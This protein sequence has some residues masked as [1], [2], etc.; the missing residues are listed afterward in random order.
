MCPDQQEESN[1]QKIENLTTCTA[2]FIFEQTHFMS[3]ARVRNIIAEIYGKRAIDV[4]IQSNIAGLG[5][6]ESDDT[7]YATINRI[8][9]ASDEA[10]AEL[11]KACHAGDIRKVRELLNQTDP[12]YDDNTAIWLATEANR[13]DIVELLMADVRVDPSSNNNIALRSA[14]EYGLAD[15]VRLLLRDKRVVDA[16]LDESIEIAQDT[17]HH[18]IVTMLKNTQEQ[19]RPIE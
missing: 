1:R 3:S 11:C 13:P 2:L 6:S 18:H 5:F 12:S 9:T 15:I 7:C 14:S 17:G 10:S 4:E 8:E 19:E 16:G